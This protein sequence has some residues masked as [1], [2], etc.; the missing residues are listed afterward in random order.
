MAVCPLHLTNDSAQDLPFEKVCLH[1]E[2]LSVFKSAA[3]LWT[4]GLNV[5]FKGPEQATQIQITGSV[6]DF[7]E[8]LALA[9]RARQP[10]EGWNIR[11]TFNMLK[12]FTEF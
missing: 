3:R 5:V 6:P 1:V 9:S 2:N 12:Y 4:N 10:A 8:N 11:K 7:E